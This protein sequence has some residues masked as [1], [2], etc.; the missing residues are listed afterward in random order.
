MPTTDSQNRTSSQILVIAVLEFIPKLFWP[1]IA[2]IA[3][4]TFESPIYEAIR[5]VSVQIANGGA[6]IEISGLKV[7]LSKNEIPPPPDDVKKVLPQLDAKLIEFIV[8]NVGGNN[9]L[10]IC[11]H[12]TNPEEFMEDS[13]SNR[14]R[15]LD[16]ITFEKEPWHESDG[17]PCSIGSKTKYTPL[18]DVVRKYLIDV[19]KSI[20]FTKQA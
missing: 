20:T 19:L 11:Y 15:K 4:L 13:V 17:T 18:Y 10:D 12:D 1:T 3:L 6:S 8:A 9:T 7:A 5:A 16:L 14:L 2:I